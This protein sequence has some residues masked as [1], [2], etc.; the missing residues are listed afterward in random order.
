[1][2]KNNLA[3]KE[4]F[5]AADDATAYVLADPPAVE[6]RTLLLSYDEFTPTPGI[7]PLEGDRLR[8]T[9]DIPAKAT[10][11]VRSE[12]SIE[13]S[14]AD[15]CP[16]GLAL[17]FLAGQRVYNDA[18]GAIKETDLQEDKTPFYAD[19]AAFLNECQ[20][21]AQKK[22]NAFMKGD[23]GKTRDTS[24]DPLE[25]EILQL[26]FNQFTLNKW[27]IKKSPTIAGVA[28]FDADFSECKD[29]GEFKER[30]SA[31]VKKFDAIFRKKAIRALE[32]RAEMEAEIKA[33]AGDISLT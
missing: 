3:H 10:L 18:V 9:F 19:K 20:S 15:F 6:A 26:G 23:P 25:R 30:V 32:D 13:I 14:Y 33:L 5:V 22:L 27:T 21:R 16:E 8:V 28:R 17:Q 1:M 2:A 4:A 7:L 29:Y 31:Y 11:K 24:L 12:R